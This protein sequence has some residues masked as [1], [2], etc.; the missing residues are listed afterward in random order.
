M[1]GTGMNSAPEISALKQKS[2]KSDDICYVK[3]YMFY[4]YLANLYHWVHAIK[5]AFF[6]SFNFFYIL[7]ILFAQITKFNTNK[8]NLYRKIDM[9]RL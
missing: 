1:Y 5:S 6:S 4:A 7:H 2:N 8:V 9:I 3:I